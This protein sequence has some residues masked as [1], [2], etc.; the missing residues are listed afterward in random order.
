MS[1]TRTTLDALK[2]ALGATGRNPT[3]S[4]RGVD[5]DW[6]V[7]EPTMAIESIINFIVSDF[8]AMDSGYFDMPKF[9]G[10]LKQSIREELT[11]LG[12]AAFVTKSRRLKP[13]AFEPRAPKEGEQYAEIREVHFNQVQ[14]SISLKEPATRVA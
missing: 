3:F 6:D 1:D 11:K 8:N 13:E 7:D 12:V 4:Y 5:I 14:V 2:K 9:L 10:D